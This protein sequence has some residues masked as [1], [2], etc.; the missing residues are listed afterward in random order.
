MR[1]V[2]GYTRRLLSF[3]LLLCLL[4]SCSVLYPSKTRKY[5]RYPVRRG[6]T[7]YSISRRF[8]V[9]VRTIERENGIYNPRSLK[10]GQIIYI[11][12]HGQSLKYKH[13]VTSGRGWSAA[14]FT[15]SKRHSRVSTA[16][17]GRASKY[18]GRLLWPVRGGTITSRFG[19]RWFSFHEGIDIAAP[20][21]TPV[22]AAHSGQVV[23]SSNGIRGYGNLVIIKGDGLLT[24]Y[25]HNRRNR[26]RRGQYVRR[27]QLIAEVGQT[28]HATGPH[29]HFETRILN[30]RGRH[31]AIDPSVFYR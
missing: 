1:K 13:R 25:A 19:R 6:D 3:I 24:V 18:V 7:L 27:G 10:P 23:Y 11:P 4:S 9:S 17:L 26:V 21:G 15:M 22:Y 2:F 31:Q 20:S 28:G 29:V 16:Q 12:Y 30:S 14:G 8:D 5:I